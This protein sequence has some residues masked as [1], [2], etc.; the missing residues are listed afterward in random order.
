MKKYYPNLDLIKIICALL[1]VFHHYQQLS[2]ARFDYINFYGGRFVFGFLVELF[3]IISGFVCMMTDKDIEIN[4][5]LKHKLA[6]IYPSAILA[7]SVC[8]II[9]LIY[10]SITGDLWYGISV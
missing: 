6:R 8:T 7:T 1:I 9:S 10:F 3:F 2:G 5:A 4:Q